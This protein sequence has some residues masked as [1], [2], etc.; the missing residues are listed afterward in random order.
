MKAFLL[1]LVVATGGGTD[2]DEF[3]LDH[4]LTE[5]D[6]M[7]K[8]ATMPPSFILPEY[9]LEVA[10]TCMPMDDEDMA[11]WAETPENADGQE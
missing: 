2:R 3:V 8:L 7:G 11:A 6:C 4:D 10:P 9:G 1:L 5:A